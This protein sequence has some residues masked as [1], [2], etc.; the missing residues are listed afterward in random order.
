GNPGPSVR[1][2]IIRDN[3]ANYL[4]CFASNIGVSD[5]FSAE[6]IG[7]ITAIEIPCL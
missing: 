1:G 4:G 3:Q 5:D 2:G 6:L 7:A